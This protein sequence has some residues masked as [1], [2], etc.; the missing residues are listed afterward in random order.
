MTAFDTDVLWA[1][2]IAAGMLRECTI[3]SRGGAKT[4]WVDYNEPDTARFE[5]AARSKD[6]TIE[7]QV[8]DFPNIAEGDPV[9][10]LDDEHEPVAGKFTVRAPSFVSDRPLDGLDGRYRFA[11]LTKL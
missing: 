6:Y 9:V 10:F 1:A 8:K 3:K 4:G 7:Y 5:G 11:L 2:A